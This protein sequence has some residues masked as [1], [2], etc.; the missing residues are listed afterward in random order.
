MFCGN[1]GNIIEDNAKWC[2]NCGAQVGNSNTIDSAENRNGIGLQNEHI[3]TDKT[4]YSS[5]GFLDFV[6]YFILVFGVGTIVF[7]LKDIAAALIPGFYIPH[8]VS[9]P[10]YYVQQA[11]YSIIGHILSFNSQGADISSLVATA[12]MSLTAIML[13]YSWKK[14]P[15][16]YFSLTCQSTIFLI[17]GFI[18]LFCG[19]IYSVFKIQSWWLSPQVYIMIIGAIISLGLRVYLV[20]YFSSKV[21]A[22]D[23]I[24]DISKIEHKT[25]FGWSVFL[26]VVCILDLMPVFRYMIINGFDI[27][28]APTSVWSSIPLSLLC[29]GAGFSGIMSASNEDWYVSAFSNSVAILISFVALIPSVVKTF[30]PALGSTA[31]IGGLG[32]VVDAVLIFYLAIYIFMIIAPIV[33]IFEIRDKLFNND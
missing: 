17:M 21:K 29:F 33:L 30:F 19:T 10:V 11:F 13:F 8:P 22:L 18:F 31:S 1:C 27:F 14:F 15:N 20:V 6:M 3:N 5:A 4:L 24:K 26:I 2:G 9:Q 12:A 25:L 23:N 28:S 16:R 7:V 32:F